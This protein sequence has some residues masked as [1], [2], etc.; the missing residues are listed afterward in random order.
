MCL[1]SRRRR[2][3]AST[4]GRSWTARM[5]KC[6]CFA[7]ARRTPALSP[8]RSIR[9]HGTHEGASWCTCSPVRVTKSAH[10]AVSVSPSRRRT[11]RGFLLFGPRA[12]NSRIEQPHGS[13]VG[14]YREHVEDLQP[15]RR[16]RAHADG[17]EVLRLRGVREREAGP[18]DD[19]VEERGAAHHAKRRLREPRDERPRRDVAL[20]EVVR[21]LQLRTR[22]EDLRQPTR[23]LLSGASQ[24]RRC[25]PDSPY[26][27]K[28]R[29]GN[30][31][32]RPSLNLA[33]FIHRA[34]RPPAGRLSSTTTWTPARQPSR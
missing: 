17:S 34:A 30:L 29:R 28:F 7:A 32:L 24:H 25:A 4:T 15:S 21:G 6:P 13:A 18:I 23:R 14:S 33:A 19:R 5:V 10:R 9:N 20:D 8:S 16:Q 12:Q 27:A 11:N 26:V 2:P 1:N 3:F 22:F 31:L